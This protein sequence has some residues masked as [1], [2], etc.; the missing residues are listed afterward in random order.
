MIK[1][2]DEKFSNFVKWLSKT[3]PT[4]QDV[5]VSVMHGHD[6]LQVED[7]TSYGVYIPD[8]N[9]V[10]F[11]PSDVPEGIN[12]DSDIYRFE[13]FA[14]EYAHHIQNCENR[15]EESEKTEK[16]AENFAKHSVNVYKQMLGGDLDGTDP[17]V[18]RRCI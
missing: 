17:T 15:L 18:F 6:S 3:Y 5:Y 10:I 11:I 7:C 8:D 14:H 9:P 1:F 13:C 4:S 12:I 2:A 16:E